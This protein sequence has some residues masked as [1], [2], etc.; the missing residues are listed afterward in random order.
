MTAPA[1]R[2]ESPDVR[3]G[4]A[5]HIGHGWFRCSVPEIQDA[6]RAGDRLGVDWFFEIPLL[7]AKG[8]VGFKHDEELPAGTEHGF[9][10]LRLLDG[11]SLASGRRPW[12]RFW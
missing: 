7:L 9:V 8:I 10:A 6:E 2:Q 11:G 4:T 3:V 1:N 12:W 5:F